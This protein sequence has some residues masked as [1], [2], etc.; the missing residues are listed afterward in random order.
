MVIQ[1]DS[2]WHLYQFST[3]QSLD[4]FQDVYSKPLWMALWG[5]LERKDLENSKQRQLSENTCQ[6]CLLSC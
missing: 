3:K 5:D 4:C 1:K 2:T 6:A